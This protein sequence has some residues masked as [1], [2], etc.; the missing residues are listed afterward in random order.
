M[1]VNNKRDCR[2]C[3]LRNLCLIS[4]S[5]FES[6]DRLVC[7]KPLRYHTFNTNLSLT[8]N[9]SSRYFSTLYS[10]FTFKTSC[11]KKDC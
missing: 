11:L 6:D 4:W 7:D 3:L 5:F 1:N 9:L 2:R 8:L 10:E